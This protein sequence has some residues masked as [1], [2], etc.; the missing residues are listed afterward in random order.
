LARFIRYRHTT[1]TTRRWQTRWV[2]VA[3]L[4][5]MLGFGLLWA[6]LLI[7]PDLRVGRI[8]MPLAIFTFVLYLVP[9][10]LTPW[11]MVLSMLRRRLW[12]VELV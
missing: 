1:E 8:P 2:M 11:Y 6:F 12:D 4:G 10:L 7:S 3:F 9:W 5:A